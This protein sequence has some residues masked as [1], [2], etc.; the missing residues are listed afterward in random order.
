MDRI[1]LYIG[2][3]HERFNG[4][5]FPNRLKGN[6]IP[7]GGRILAVVEA[8]EEVQIKKKDVAQLLPKDAALLINEYSGTAFCPEA[9][10]LLLKVLGVVALPKKI[11]IPVAEENTKAT[12]DV[13]RPSIKGVV[14]PVAPQQESVTQKSDVLVKNLLTYSE[15][16]SVVAKYPGAQVF[17]E[18]DQANGYLWV[19][20][21]G[22]VDNA[23]PKLV[24][25]LGG[26]KF[27]LKAEKGWF[28]PI[29]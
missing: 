12:E 4:S 29:L 26:H 6:A 1:A 24:K 14:S 28:L 5:G 2:T 3:H 9:C 16:L 17:D 22:G 10:K 27:L 23:N 8:F 25:W 19:R 21:A 13:V 18:R 15:L 11:Q 7:L 20:Q